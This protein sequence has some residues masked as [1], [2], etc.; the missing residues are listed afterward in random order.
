MSD[1]GKPTWEDDRD[2][3]PNNPLPGLL[4]FVAVIFVIGMLVQYRIW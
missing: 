2:N 4:I 3:D 1:F